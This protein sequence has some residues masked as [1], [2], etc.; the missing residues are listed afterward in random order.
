MLEL[1]R[2]EDTCPSAHVQHVFAVRPAAYRLEPSLRTQ[3]EYLGPSL[4]PRVQVVL[5]QRI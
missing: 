5:G 3:W 4:A 2:S 1:C